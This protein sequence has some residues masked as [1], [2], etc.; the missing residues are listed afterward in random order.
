M[1]G[2]PNAFQAECFY[3]PHWLF[4]PKR[5][6]ERTWLTGWYIGWPPVNHLTHWLSDRIMNWLITRLE[7]LA[8]V[9]MSALNR[10][11]VY[12]TEELNCVTG[13]PP[14]NTLIYEHRP[15]RNQLIR[16]WIKL[17]SN[18]GESL[19]HC[20]LK[21][22]GSYSWGDWLLWSNLIY[23]YL[24]RKITKYSIQTTLNAFTN[25]PRNSLSF[26]PYSRYD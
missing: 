3:L 15:R 9:T 8:S 5:P 20:V 10:V 4:L 12:L 22:H 11:F 18:W 23:F 24:L 16:P 14:G 2:F 19:L 13:W 7:W 26:S 17:T 1:S 25:I 21:V 6:I